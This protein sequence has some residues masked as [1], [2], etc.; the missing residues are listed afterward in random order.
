MRLA[1]GR[2]DTIIVN[3]RRAAPLPIR[4]LDVAGRP[5]AGAPIRY[6]WAGGDSLPVDTAGTVT[7][8]RPG[9]LFVRV[10]LGSISAR[11]FIRCRPVEYVRFPGPVQFILGDSEMNR[12]VP[13]PVTAYGA[14]GRPVVVFAGRAEV[15]DSGVAT[16]RGLILYPRSRGISV[17]GVYIGERAAWTGVHV[18]QRVDTLAALDTLLRVDPE[19]RLFAV[20]LRLERGEFTRQ[21]LPPGGWMLTMLPEEDNDPNP[22]RIRIEG[23]ACQANIFNTARRFVCFA[24]PSASVIIYRPFRGSQTSVERGYLL[25]RWVF[26]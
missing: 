23:A 19:Q 21:R 25:V 14:D 24:G 13:L 12:P 7:C 6:A 22:I 10:S 20:P 1:T 4:A 11:L 5:V 16:L 2:S 26:T 8:A 18:Y 9:D 15:L 3:S 17:A